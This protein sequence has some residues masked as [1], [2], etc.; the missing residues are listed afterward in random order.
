MRCGDYAEKNV[1]WNYE[2]VMNGVHRSLRLLHAVGLL[3]CDI[4]TNN[5]MSFGEHQS[6]QLID[7]G[8]GCKIGDPVQLIRDSVQFKSAGKTVTELRETCN[9]YVWTVADDYEMANKMLDAL[10]PRK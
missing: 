10:F 4:R 9:S 7:M 3:H 2:T 6:Y 5:V 1:N 8:L